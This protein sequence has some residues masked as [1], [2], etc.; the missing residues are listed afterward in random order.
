MR[1]NFKFLAIGI[2]FL[3]IGLGLNQLTLAKLFPFLEPR[4]SLPREV[5]IGLFNV[6]FSVLGILF[7][8]FRDNKKKALFSSILFSLS[9]LIAL[10][11]AEI[12]IKVFSETIDY[13]PLTKPSDYFKFG[14]PT[15]VIFN[16]G[17]E[18][19]RKSK[20]FEVNFTVNSEGF[21]SS[22]EFIEGGPNQKTI[23]VLGDSFVAALEVAEKD[24]FVKLLES[25]L[26]NLGVKQVQ[27]Y[28]M[29]GTG[30]DY[31][32]QTYQYYAKQHKPYLVVI[33]VLFNDIP[34]FG[35]LQSLSSYSSYGFLNKADAFLQ[36]NSALYK[37][38]YLQ[39]ERSRLEVL[40][41]FPKDGYLY[42]SPWS[43]DLKKTYQQFSEKLSQL[44]YEIKKDGA[45]PVVV[46]MPS[47]IESSNAVW[48]ELEKSY[49]LIGGKNKLD[50]DRLRNELQIL[51]DKTGVDFI[52]PSDAFRKSYDSGKP[53]HN[54]YD[55]HFNPDG[56]RA[57]AE[58]LA[59]KIIINSQ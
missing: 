15:G 51:T 50:R 30:I 42:E 26:S 46:W 21:R 33:A 55:H 40:H 52:D 47:N 27:N 13:Y 35:S 36:R 14:P 29:P 45:K 10:V 19:T 54:H 28:G 44:I 43:D 24:T 34:D 11:G 53:L 49:S 32:L 57:V 37:F 22:Q 58:M 31:Y 3:I 23:A 25:K 59:D 4:L 48:E 6:F 41:I 7:I 1:N 39:Y 20:E 18:G 9:L 38:I 8:V 12:L 56:H 5:L 17:Y 16:P 2:F